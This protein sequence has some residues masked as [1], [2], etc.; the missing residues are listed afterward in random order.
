MHNIYF[1]ILHNIL[2]GAPMFTYISCN[3]H[4]NA[5][6]DGLWEDIT[7]LRCEDIAVFHKGLVGNLP[8]MVTNHTMG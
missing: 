3:V 2:S 1:D 7:L 4:D 6:I 8:L 5:C